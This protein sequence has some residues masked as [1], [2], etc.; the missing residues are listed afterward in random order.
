MVDINVTVTQAQPIAVE[1][2]VGKYSSDYTDSEAIAAI[3]NDSDHGST[4]AHNYFSGA[5]VAKTANYT[6]TSSDYLVECTASTFTVTLP[7]AVGIEGRMYSIKNTGTGTI[8]VSG[9]E[10]ID[11][12]PT[13][14]VSQWS[15]LKVMSNGANWLII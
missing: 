14:T 9:S 13:Q 11:G 6:L 5:Y 4:A 15:N 3:N 12:E 8:T 7:T 2:T 1:S 10:T